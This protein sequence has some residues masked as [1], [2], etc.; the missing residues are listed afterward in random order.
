ME[1]CPQNAWQHTGG[2]QNKLDSGEKAYDEHRRDNMKG[3]L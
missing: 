1:V 3:G 2:V